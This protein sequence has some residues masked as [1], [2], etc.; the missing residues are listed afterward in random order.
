MTWVTDTLD[1]DPNF[2]YG[3]FHKYVEDWKLLLK[4]YNKETRSKGTKAERAEVLA[5]Y[6]Q[7]IQ[8]SSLVYLYDDVPKIVF[9]RILDSRTW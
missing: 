7:V 2:E 8:C 5:T 3:E 6:K 1:E 4:Q 9:F